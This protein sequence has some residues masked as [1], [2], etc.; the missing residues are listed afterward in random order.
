MNKEKETDVR[1]MNQETRK[2][3]SFDNA[4]FYNQRPVQLTA[5]SPSYDDKEQIINLVWI[6]NH[7]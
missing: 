3:C 7:P 5:S 1:Q 4:K 6:G 2:K